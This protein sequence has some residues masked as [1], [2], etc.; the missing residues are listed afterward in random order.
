MH[1]ESFAVFPEHFVQDFTQNIF[2][3]TVHKNYTKTW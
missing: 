3:V 2:T 1:S